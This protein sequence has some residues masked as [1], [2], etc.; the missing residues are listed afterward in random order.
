[1]SNKQPTRTMSKSVNWFTPAKYMRAVRSVLGEIE[2]DVASC[3]EANQTIQATR[4]YTAENDGLQHSW[5]ARTLWMN[6]PYGKTGN[7]SNQEIWTCKLIAEYEKGNVQEALILVNAA[8]DTNWF[9]RLWDYPI[10]FTDHR[11]CF[12]KVDTT[13][14]PTMGNAFVY[15]G[16]HGERFASV[17]DTPSLGTVVHRARKSTVPTLWKSG[18]VA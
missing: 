12:F 14:E 10:C 9:G 1:M 11:I 4:Y 17:F 2:L 5:H 15:F 18:G 3:E 6:C 8:T 7:K 16:E 13:N